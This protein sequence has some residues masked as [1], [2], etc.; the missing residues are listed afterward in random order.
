MGCEALFPEG[1]YGV[2]QLC[3]LMSCPSNAAFDAAMHMVPYMEQHKNKGI[4]FSANGNI[5]PVV[6]V[7]A[8]N[9]PDPHSGLAQAGYT[10][11]WANGPTACK[12][13]LLKHEG[14]SSEHNGYMGLTAALRFAVWMRQLLSEIGVNKLVQK[15]FNVYGDNIAANNLCKNHFVSTGNQHIFMPYHWNRRAVREGHAIVKWVQTN[16][17]I[18]DI[19]TKPLGGATFQLFLLIMS[20]WIR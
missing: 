10:S 4:L 5:D 7:D 9:K 1:K 3:K 19:M 14:L 17:N 13:S 12:S 20:A 2:S 11:H 16:M 8:S 18:S 15:P 6:M